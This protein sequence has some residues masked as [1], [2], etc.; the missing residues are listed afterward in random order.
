MGVTVYNVNSDHDNSQWLLPEIHEDRLLDHL[1]FNCNIKNKDWSDI[2]WRSYNPLHRVGNFYHASSGF[3]VFDEKVYDSD[4]F[5]LFEMAGQILPMKVGQK[6][7]FALNIM[8]CVNCLDEENTNFDTY[9]DGSRGRILKYQ[10]L[11]RYFSESSIFKIP[12]ENKHGIFT[13]SGLKDPDDEFYSLYKKLN[14]TGLIFDKVFVTPE[15]V[16]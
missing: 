6:K 16:N 8:E 14:F 15:L 13:Y 9:D 11:K 1:T 7:L 4:I 12:E 2:K 3:L 5:T 10:F